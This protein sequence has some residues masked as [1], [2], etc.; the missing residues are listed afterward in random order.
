MS[1]NGGR[2]WRFM[3]MMGVFAYFWTLFSIHDIFI[4]IYVVL[5]IP[6]IV[7]SAVI[8]LCEVVHWMWTGRW[9]GIFSDLLR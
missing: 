3:A 4:V 9:L 6:A 1:D 8:L 5:L 7:G 2:F